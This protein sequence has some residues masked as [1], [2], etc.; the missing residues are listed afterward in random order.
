[1]EQQERRDANGLMSRTFVPPVNVWPLI[2][3]LFARRCLGGAISYEEFIHHPGGTIARRFTLL[4]QWWGVE[5]PGRDDVE[6]RQQLERSMRDTIASR[7]VWE[8]LGESERRVLFAVVGPSARNWCLFEMIP[9]RSRLE[10]EEATAAL[11]SLME[12]HLVFS[13]TAKIQGGDLVGQ[14]DR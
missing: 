2:S 1:M 6:A 3:Y 8:R 13:E 5:Q 7:F 9:E 4:A 11:E 10:P 14:R 12:Q